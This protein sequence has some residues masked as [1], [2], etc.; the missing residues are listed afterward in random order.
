MQVST[1]RYE[2]ELNKQKFAEMNQKKMSDVENLQ[3]EYIDKINS[4]EKTIENQRA[5]IDFKNIE[6]LNSKSRRSL[7]NSTIMPPPPQP[8]QRE[9]LS[10]A[11]CYSLYQ[12]TEIRIP[13]RHCG[14]F[15]LLF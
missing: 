4:L 1:L 8:A 12:I 3:K 9:L 14:K 5:E 13:E 2:L 10:G 7:N 15:I 11:D 6:I